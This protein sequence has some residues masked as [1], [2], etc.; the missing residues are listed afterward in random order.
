MGCGGGRR[1]WKRLHEHLHHE[2]LI[3]TSPR[4]G[5]LEETTSFGVVGVEPA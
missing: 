4:G 1:G 3:R 5:Q 2:L